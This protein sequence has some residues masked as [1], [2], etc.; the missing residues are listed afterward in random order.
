[1]RQSAKQIFAAADAS[2][3]QTSDPIQAQNLFNGS[4]TGV[5]TGASTGALKIQVSNDIPNPVESVP[6][7]IPT[8]TNWADLSGVTV[9]LSAAGVF[10]IPKFDICYEWIRLVYTKNNGSAGTI[11]ANLKTLGA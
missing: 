11:S 5:V 4:V 7:V 8:I 10:I 3:N 2:A 1:M 9:T 6:G